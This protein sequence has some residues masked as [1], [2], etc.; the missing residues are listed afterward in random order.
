MPRVKPYIDKKN[1]MM[2]AFVRAG[3]GAM[4]INVKD[5]SRKTGIPYSTLYS[6]IGNSG[7]IGTL[8]FCEYIAIS[9]VFEKAGVLD[10][11]QAARG[12]VR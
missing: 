6:R 7:D 3:M 11:A 9:D 4:Q 2:R 5:L 1:A 8:N 10:I 12:G